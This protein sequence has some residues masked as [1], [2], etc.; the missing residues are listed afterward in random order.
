MNVPTPVARHSLSGMITQLSDDECKDA[1]SRNSS[2]R[3]RP[4]AISADL[5]GR[6]SENGRGLGRAVH[7]AGVGLRRHVEH[8]AAAQRTQPF[9]V[10]GVRP[11][12]RHCTANREP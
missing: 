7:V 12:Q 3:I 5:R 1:G 10:F 2:R 8:R 9:D 4:T 11:D 6:T